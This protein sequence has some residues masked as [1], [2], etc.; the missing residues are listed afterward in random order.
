MGQT[1]QYDDKKLVQRC[2]EGDSEAFQI[3]VRRYQKKLFSI[4]YGMLHHPEDALDI[5]QEAFLKIHRYLPNFQGNSSFYTW[6]Y[7]IV[8]NLCIDFIRKDSRYSTLDY[9]DSVQHDSPISQQKGEFFFTNS[10]NPIQALKNKELGQQIWTAIGTLSPNHRAVIILRE[11]EGMSYEELALTLECSKGTIMSRL[12][13]A[14][15]KLRVVL[16]Q[17]LVSGESIDKNHQYDEK[18]EVIAEQQASE[19]KKTLKKKQTFSISETKNSSFSSIIEA[20]GD[21]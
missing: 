4:A 9:N 21:K 1:V 16:S 8:V 3:I 10:I 18:P 7:R 17:Y 2:H 20:I 15:A 19:V 13:H 11:I 6:S 5:V 14:R 12:H